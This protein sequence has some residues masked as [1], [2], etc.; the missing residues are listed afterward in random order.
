MMCGSVIID[1]SSDTNN[2]SIKQYI[3]LINN[4]MNTL[5]NQSKLYNDAT[6]ID[7][8]DTITDNLKII[9]EKVDKLNKSIKPNDD[10]NEKVL[11]LLKIINHKI[12]DHSHR[13]NELKNTLI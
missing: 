7:S 9:Y 3:S 4:G 5:L 2:V 1:D 11:S 13:L 6:D 10:S 12:D 8:S